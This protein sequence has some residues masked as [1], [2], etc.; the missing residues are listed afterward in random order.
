MLSGF[1]GIFCVMKI[2]TVHLV[3][4]SSYGLSVLAS[5]SPRATSPLLPAT[6]V[7]LTGD[8]ILHSASAPRTPA[9]LQALVDHR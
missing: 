2:S 4:R 3:C 6:P 7:R 8:E 5:M 9:V 1:T